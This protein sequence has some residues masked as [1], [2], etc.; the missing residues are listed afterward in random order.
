[1]NANAIRPTVMKAI[2]KPRKGLGTMLY[3]IFSRTAAKSMI[4][5]AQPKPEPSAKATESQKLRIA[6]ELLAS[7]LI[8]CCINSEPPMMAQFTAIRGKKIPN[9]A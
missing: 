2:P 1:M 9:E 8:L 5:N 3:S 7:I 4:A 6:C